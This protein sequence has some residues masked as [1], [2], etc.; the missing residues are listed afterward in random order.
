MQISVKSN[1]DQLSRRIRSYRD[2]IPQATAAALTK[3]AF[4]IRQEIVQNTWPKSVIARNKTFM[5][6][7]LQIEVA[8]KK[9][10]SVVLFDSLRK[11]YLARLDSSGIRIPTGN[12]LA[13]PGREVKDQIRGANGAVKKN[14]KPS[15]LLNKKRFFINTLKTG[16]DAILERPAGKEQGKRKK[17]RLKRGPLKVWYLLE[18][19]AN[20]PKIFPFYETA[21]RI[22]KSKLE[23]NFRNAFRR[24]VMTRR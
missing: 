5:S 12:H 7:A 19:R 4:D 10:L 9:K 20:I 1:V 15:A 3:T 14:F 24:A 2:Q 17:K 8:T 6:K 21:N 22:L 23:T 16:I 13:I 11:E 18:P